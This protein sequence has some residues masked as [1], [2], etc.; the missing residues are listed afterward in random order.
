M[1]YRFLLFIFLGLTLVLGS[2]EQDRKTWYIPEE[3]EENESLEDWAPKATVMYTGR[4][5]DTDNLEGRPMYPWWGEH[6]VI[7][8]YNNTDFEPAVMKRWVDTI[9]FVFEFYYKCT[10]RMPGIADVTFIDGRISIAAT[11]GLPA[12]AVAGVGYTGI[13]MNTDYFYGAYNSYLVGGEENLSPYEMG[14]NFWFFGDKIATDYSG[15]PECTGYSIFTRMICNELLGVNPGNDPIIGLFDEYMAS[16]KTWENTIGNNEGISA[17]ACDLFASFLYELQSRYGGPT[18]SSNS[19]TVSR[20]V[21]VLLTNMSP[22]TTSSS[23]HR[24]RQARTFAPYSRNGG[25][26]YPITQGP[27]YR[28]SGSFK[29]KYFSKHILI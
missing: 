7:L 24:R 4:F 10:R 16:D 25:G 27:G 1:K 9:D 22:S 15:E 18:G 2:C 11:D 17:N 6:M 13:W 5:Y 3:S 19:G 12:A 20:N 28:V 21:Q 26:P 23:P 8:S 14:R 29:T